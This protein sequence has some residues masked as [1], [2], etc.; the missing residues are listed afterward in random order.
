MT[1]TLWGQMSPYSTLLTTHSP[2]SKSKLWGVEMVPTWWTKI[3][4]CQ[5]FSIH[6]M[7]NYPTIIRSWASYTSLVIGVALMWSWQMVTTLNCP[8]KFK[9]DAVTLL[10]IKNLTVPVSKKLLWRVTMSSVEWC[11][12]ILIIRKFWKQD[13]SQH[14]MPESLCWK[15]MK[16]LLE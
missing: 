2:H 15:T 4:K 11:S 10:F 13:M 12:T 7:R 1:L 16:D 5:I 3:T 9:M 8:W 6:Q 14:S